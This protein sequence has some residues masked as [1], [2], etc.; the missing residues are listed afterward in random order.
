MTL[1]LLYLPLCAVIAVVYQATHYE[2]IEDVPGPALRLFVL[3]TLALLLI[4]GVIAGVETA[5]S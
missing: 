5:F 2:R 1:V 4:A 3:F